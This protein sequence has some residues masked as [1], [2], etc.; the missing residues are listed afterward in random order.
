[1]EVVEIDHG[2]TIT[3][4]ERKLAGTTRCA[5]GR[6]RVVRSTVGTCGSQVLERGVAFA[7]ENRSDSGT[8]PRLIVSTD[9]A[10]EGQLATSKPSGRFAPL[11]GMRAF[12]VLAVILFHAYTPW[13]IGGY[14]GV[15]VFFVLSG[16]LITGLL[17]SEW[18]RREAISLGHFW[19]R[20]AR[21]LLPAL[22]VMLAVVLLIANVWPSVL[23]SPG[24]LWDSVATLFYSS[25]WRF[26]AEHANYFTAATNPSPLLHTWTLA[27]EEQFYLVWP[28]VVLGVL[29]VFRRRDHGGGDVA[30]RT[31]RRRSGRRAHMV[32]LAIATIGALASALL[33]G[34]LTPFGSPDVNR[35]YYGSDTRAQAILIGAALALGC[36]LWAPVIRP[37]SRR[38]LAAVGVLGAVVVVGMWRTV[39]Q[40]SDFAFHG[41]FAVVSL[42]AAGV[43]LCVTQMP[44]HPMA[45]IIGVAPLS[46]L[47]R[48]SYGMYLWYWPVLLVITPERFALSPLG[49]LALRIG[50]IVVLAALSFRLIE[51]PIRSG[52][53]RGWRTWVA[54]PSAAS[55]VAVLAL[56]LPASTLGSTP[57]ALGVAAPVR[58]QQPVT[59]RAES[60]ALVQPP[61]AMRVVPPPPGQPRSG[62][63]LPPVRILMVGD[64][65]AGTLAVGLS[66]VAGRYGAQIMNMG[67]P[68]CYLSSGQQ[69]QELWYT[70]TPSAPCQPG[71]PNAL[72]RQ[73][74]DWVDEYDPDVVVYLA[75]SDTYDTEVDGTWEHLG[76][77]PFDNYV[78]SRYRAALPV[79]SSKGARVV[80]LSPP[81]SNPGDNGGGLPWPES[82]PAR[83]VVDG[84]LIDRA[85][86]SDPKVASVINLDAL[87][88]PGNQ[89]SLVVHGVT[90]R[91]TD[92]VHLSVTG[93]EWLAPR[94]L[95]KLVSLGRPHLLAA[96]TMS[97]PQIQPLPPPPW[98]SKLPCS[99]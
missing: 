98:Y 4:H 48:I 49:L 40:T 55:L 66:T 46:Y 20:R 43:I 96:S 6:Q 71:D 68:G 78:L 87:V 91:C 1:M 60:P 54:L 34:A 21:R 32:L 83:V 11:D 22:L 53:W 85:A 35:T 51:S 65:M 99:A 72:L 41:G 97:R 37:M 25:N 45:R 30:A 92:G 5:L 63:G 19:A 33:M 74:R 62:F 29:T 18:R 7:W 58:G 61:V 39:P 59:L 27:I 88:S 17:V 26:M 36:A 23:G 90:M 93:G 24:L 56:A 47:G 16:Y 81:V 89:F 50:V 42:A 79:L 75:R 73:M 12:A 76:Q 28:I 82:D 52:A 67:V 64:S 31:A 69:F 13:A 94:L 80:L 44:R 15:D 2:E 10:G 86:Q 3:F 95:P 9:V 70:V 77:A 84:R 8:L 57:D 14:Y 38:A